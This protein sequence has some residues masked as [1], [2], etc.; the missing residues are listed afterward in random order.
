MEGRDG[1]LS[2]TVAHG[3]QAADVYDMGTKV[4]VYAD[5]DA[6]KAQAL[7]ERLGREIL[8]WGPGGARPRHLQA[9]RG[10]R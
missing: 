9:R 1:I 3:F 7:A 5:G 4:L 10:D 8:G 6:A 2:I